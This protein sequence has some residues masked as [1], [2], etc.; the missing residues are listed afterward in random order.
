VGRTY[1]P[2]QRAG[3][4]KRAP[5]PSPGLTTRGGGISRHRNPAA[6][7]DGDQL[8][9]SGPGSLRTT[10]E[11]RTGPQQLDAGATPQTPRRRASRIGWRPFG[12]SARTSHVRAI[13]RRPNRS[14]QRRRALGLT[15]PSEKSNDRRV[16]PERSSQ[17]AGDS[18]PTHVEP[19]LRAVANQIRKRPPAHQQ[20]TASRNDDAY[21]TSK[22]RLVNPQLAP[23]IHLLT[24]TPT[25]TLRPRH[26]STHHLKRMRLSIATR[27]REHARQLMWITRRTERRDSATHQRTT[28]N[29]MPTLRPVLSHHAARTLSTPPS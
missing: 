1:T 11:A 14:D 4:H 17:S 21:E 22:P 7:G 25:S 26:S 19:D 24:T 6:K 12:R 5:P 20:Q 29:T 27:I 23:A 28:L 8:P 13:V 2:H 16:S 15:A 18:Q 10:Q 3:D 9:R